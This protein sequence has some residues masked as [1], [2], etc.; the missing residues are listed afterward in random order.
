M[1]VKGGERSSKPKKL[2]RGQEVTNI[3]KL[4]FSSSLKVKTTFQKAWIVGCYLVYPEYLDN[5]LSSSILISPAPE[6]R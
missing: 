1:I 2:G 5:F 6:I 4:D 3:N